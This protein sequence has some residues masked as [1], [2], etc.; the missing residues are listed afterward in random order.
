M[1]E[2][3]NRN[4]DNNQ[5]LSHSPNCM[6]GEIR[7]D[8]YIRYFC[9]INVH[10]YSLLCPFAIPT[11]MDLRVS[12]N[13]ADIWPH[14]PLQ[15]AMSLPALSLHYLPLCPST[16]HRRGLDSQGSHFLLRLLISPRM[17]SSSLRVLTS[18]QFVEILFKQVRFKTHNSNREWSVSRMKEV[19]PMGIQWEGRLLQP[20]ALG[21]I[22][23]NRWQLHWAFILKTEW[24]M[25]RI[26]LYWSRMGKEFHAERTSRDKS[27]NKECVKQLIVFFDGNTCIKSEIRE[28]R[29]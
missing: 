29:L 21:R 26:W 4:R 9:L 8:K 13:K 16:P 24:I 27:W 12:L 19:R 2:V 23:W 20:S 18:Y 3:E 1:K 5:S 17:P 25:S 7:L 14:I 11:F 10:S 15:S 6:C 22:S 28:N